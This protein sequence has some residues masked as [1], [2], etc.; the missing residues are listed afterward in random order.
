[1]QLLRLFLIMCYKFRNIYKKKQRNWAIEAE[2][3]QNYLNTDLSPSLSDPPTNVS[4]KNVLIVEVWVKSWYITYY[5]VSSF[6]VFVINGVFVFKDIID[7]GKTMQTLL[8]LL[9]Q[10]NPKMVKVAR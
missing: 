2:S 6:M 9:K 7:T 5:N 4:L 3:V 1:M 8:E 10:Y